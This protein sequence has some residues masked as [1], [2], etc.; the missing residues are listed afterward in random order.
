[1]P[2][3]DS[4]PA[5]DPLPIAGQSPNYPT[6]MSRHQKSQG[7]VPPRSSGSADE[8]EGGGTPNGLLFQP[9]GVTKVP[10]DPYAKYNGSQR[11]M[12]RQSV[13]GPYPLPPKLRTV[14]LPSDTLQRFVALAALNTAKKKETLGV[15]YG[16]ANSAGGYDINSLVIPRQSSTE[17]T[18]VMEQEEMLVEFS[19]SRVG[20]VCLGWVSESQSDLPVFGPTALMLTSNFAADPHASNTVLL[21]VVHGPPYTFWVPEF[22]PGGNRD[23]LCTTTSAKVRI[24]VDYL[25]LVTSPDLSLPLFSLSALVSSV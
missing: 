9:I 19:E 4:P 14:K 22:A 24:T 12:S 18:C 25:L 20:S 8:A 16:R 23:R 5:S 10:T 1:M 11:T 15:L 7:Y 2:R 13:N 17:N 21:H 3:T 6:Q